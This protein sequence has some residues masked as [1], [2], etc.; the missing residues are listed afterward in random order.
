[1]SQ[2]ISSSKRVSSQYHLTLHKQSSYRDLPVIVS[3]EL[4]SEYLERLYVAI[5][6]AV[7]R[8]TKVFAVR[9]DLHFP[10]YYCP[11]S[12]GY[13]F[14]NNNL[15]LFIKSLSY[16]LKKYRDRK[17]NLGQ[18]VHDVNFKYA[19]AREG[20]FQGDK[21]HFHLLLLFNGHAF[22]T[23][24]DFS[25]DHESLYNRIRAAWAK[26]LGLH[27][28]EYG[29]FVHFPK[30]GQYILDSMEHA[31]VGD[32]FYRVSYFAKVAT[33][34]FHDGCHVFGSSRL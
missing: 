33:K 1:M 22:N 14:S 21:P 5:E 9:V 28:S 18:R 2:H 23:L 8:Y 34:N 25:D 15:Q 4:V 31:Q 7:E 11:V 26:V 30:N 12:S 32:L 13:D 29:G 20:A 19:W 6:S 16:Q 17:K 3:E 27:V 10:S 24:G